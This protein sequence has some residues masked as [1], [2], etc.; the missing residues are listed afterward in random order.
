MA[1]TVYIAPAL[2]VING[3]VQIPNTQFKRNKLT[4]LAAELLISGSVEEKAGQVTHQ[5]I[6]RLPAFERMNGYPADWF[7]VMGGSV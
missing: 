3:Y 5:K 2:P 6:L 4:P 7:A 1:T